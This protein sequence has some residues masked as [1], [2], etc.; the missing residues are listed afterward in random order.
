[1]VWYAKHEN[2]NHVPWEIFESLTC[3]RTCGLRI[4]ISRRIPQASA[5]SP[6]A[7]ILADRRINRPEKPG[8]PNQDVSAI[9]RQ[10]GLFLLRGPVGYPGI[11]PRSVC[12]DR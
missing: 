6:L 7:I 3:L 11:D 4:V 5:S 8:S 1:M 2:E 12:L 10:E 9:W